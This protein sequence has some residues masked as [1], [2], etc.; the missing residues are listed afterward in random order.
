MAK[1]KHLNKAKIEHVTQRL[2]AIESSL[3]GLAALFYW[4]GN[5]SCPDMNQFCGMGD[6]VKGL[7]RELSILADILQSGHDSRAI[8]KGWSR[9]D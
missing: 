9:E 4:Q 6:L 7:G 3:D 2:W 5:D 1:F 8:T